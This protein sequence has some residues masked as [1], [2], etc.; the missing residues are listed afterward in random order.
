M[1]TKLRSFPSAAYK[2]CLRPPY[3]VVR[4]CSSSPMVAPSISTASSLSVKGRSGVGIRILVAIG[5]SQAGLK[6]RLYAFFIKCRAI[7]LQS[8]R[9]QQFVFAGHHR[10]DHVGKR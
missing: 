6:T 1:L 2:C 8:P 7:F 5:L 9:R 4:F 10:D 3:F